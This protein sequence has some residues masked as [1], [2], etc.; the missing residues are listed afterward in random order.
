VTALFTCGLV[1]EAALYDL[2][3][4]EVLALLA[5]HP[6]QALDVVVVELPV[7]R[8][9]AFRIDESLA[10]QESDLRDR[11][12]RKLLAQQRQDV[13]D[14][15]VCPPGRHFDSTDQFVVGALTA[16]APWVTS[17]PV[18]GFT[19]RLQAGRRA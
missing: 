18:A 12:V 2:E 19:P 5:E 1:L 15:Q 17:M 7:P 8:R 16:S 6:F 4:Q 13:T 14:R 11:D 10:F 9:C 3:R